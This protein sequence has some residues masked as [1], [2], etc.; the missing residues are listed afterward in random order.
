MLRLQDVQWNDLDYMDA[1]RDFTFNSDGFGDFPAMVQE[2]HQ[3]GR[4]YVMIVVSAPPS[5]RCPSGTFHREHCPFPGDWAQAVGVALSNWFLSPP[6]SRHQQL[7]PPGELP[8]LRRGS[9]E[10]RFHHQWDGAA[11]DWEGR[12]GVGGEKAGV[13][14]REDRG[15]F[16][17]R[18]L[19]I[20]T[21]R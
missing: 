21:V 6:G 11:A 16:R 3:G 15:L 9:A 8:A 7:W 5:C 2:L 20:G 12:V 4:R 17:K 19:P 10:G 13:L 14:A 18:V 1:R